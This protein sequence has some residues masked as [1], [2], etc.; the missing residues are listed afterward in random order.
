M[1]IDSS[2]PR[3]TIIG[4]DGLIPD[5]EM[6]STR[7]HSY[8]KPSVLTFLKPSPEIQMELCINALQHVHN[9]V[10]DAIVD[11]RCA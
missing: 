7:I 9:I 1:A 8:R 6:P 10:K 2:L 4:D 3:S 5:P 11:S